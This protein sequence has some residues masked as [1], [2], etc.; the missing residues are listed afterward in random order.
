LVNIR[1]LLIEIS[2]RTALKKQSAY[3]GVLHKRFCAFLPYITRFST[4]QR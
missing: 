4:P 2:G 3:R 1:V